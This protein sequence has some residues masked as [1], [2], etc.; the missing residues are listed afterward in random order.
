M[1]TWFPWIL[2]L[3]FTVTFV[4]LAA[5]NGWSVLNY[6]VKKR[7]VSAI[8]LIGGASGALACW[9]LPVPGIGNWWWLP[10]LL[11]YGTIPLFLH[12]FFSQV[13]GVHRT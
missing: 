6:L 1:Q 5:A 2:G 10:L 8:P 12:F 3:A 4:L 13:S 7:Q 9:V 11:D